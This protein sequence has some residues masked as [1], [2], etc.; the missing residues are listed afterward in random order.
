MS[1]HPLDRRQLLS[2]AGLASLGGL[3]ALSGCT[4]GANPSDTR[5]AT[6]APTPTNGSRPPSASPTASGAPS[7]SPA[8]PRAV[9]NGSDVSHGPVS[10][11]KVALTFHGAGASAL[12][13]AVLVG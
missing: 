8:G 13:R 9:G 3:A 10:V 12:A 11:P 1:K 7:A 2:L 5:G 4:T 6:P